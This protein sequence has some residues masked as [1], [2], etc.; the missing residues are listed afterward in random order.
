MPLS[1]RERGR[2]E[3]EVAAITELFVKLKARP[4]S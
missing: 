3:G 4:V 1:Q 2:G